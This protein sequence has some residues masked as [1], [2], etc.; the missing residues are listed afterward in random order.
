MNEPFAGSRSGLVPPTRASYSPGNAIDHR[1]S[2]I[3]IIDDP[4]NNRDACARHVSR[5]TLRFINIASITVDVRLTRGE[6]NRRSLDSSFGSASICYPQIRK[7][8]ACEPLSRDRCW[9]SRTCAPVLTSK[10]EI[11]HTQELIRALYQQKWRFCTEK[12][13]EDP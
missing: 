10:L 3:V 13:C 4:A 9:I 12:P 5:L 11:S 1:R 7:D 2:S 6:N 8:Y